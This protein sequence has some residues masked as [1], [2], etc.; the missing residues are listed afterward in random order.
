MFHPKGPTFLELIRQALSSTEKGYDLLASKFEYTPFRTPDSVLRPLSSHISDLGST[1]S[2]ID[3]CCG[4]G[5]AIRMLRPL[6]RD[7]IV[8]ID[9][10]EGMLTVAQQNTKNT[11]GEANLEFFK[12]DALNLPFR[13]EFDIAICLGALGHILSNQMPLFIRQ[14]S[15]VLKP[16]G[17]FIFICYDKF[18]IWSKAL[19]FRYSFNALMY[20]RNFF[21]RP[22]FIMYYHFLLLDITS[23]LKAHGFQVEVKTLDPNNNHK[24]SR[25]RV[26]IATVVDK[27]NL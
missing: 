18:P 7:R 11:N 10:S 20:L 2:L 8:G 4:T 14:I 26:V 6:C 9:I 12:C 5:A 27:E 17:R 15:K 24:L 22:K 25:L 23:I 21:I 3:I 1:G 13:S 19:W 16:G